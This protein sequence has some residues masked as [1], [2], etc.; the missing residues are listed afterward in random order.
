[1]T[2]LHRAWDRPPCPNPRRSRKGRARRC[3]RHTPRCPRDSA[4]PDPRARPRGKRRLDAYRT[5]KRRRPAGGLRPRL[6]SAFKVFPV[7]A[8]THFAAV[9]AFM[10]QCLIVDGSRVIRRVAARI[11]EDLKFEAVEAE[12]VQARWKPAVTRC[13][14]P[15]SSTVTF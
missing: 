2:G 7:G 13:P 5:G 12:E 9:E 3:S 8:C 4:L 14:M 10:K 6:P 1:R 15:S 11:L